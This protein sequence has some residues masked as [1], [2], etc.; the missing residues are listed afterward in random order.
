[1]KYKKITLQDRP[2]TLHVFFMATGSEVSARL[3]RNKKKLKKFKPEDFELDYNSGAET[4]YLDY[5]LP[6]HYAIIFRE[7]D[8]ETIAHE[9]WHVVMDH[10][11]YIGLK[12][13]A[14]S[15]ES[16]AYLFGYLIK[17]IHEFSAKTGKVGHRK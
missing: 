4:H 14:N 8:L 2:F 11:N 7:M 9:V 3:N 16:Y 10:G 12:H 17:E 1:M 6:G 5:A 15:E 13:D